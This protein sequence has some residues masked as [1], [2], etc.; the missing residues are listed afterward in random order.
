MERK[1]ETSGFKTATNKATP[2]E[3]DIDKRLC[4]LMCR[5]RGRG[6]RRTGMTVSVGIYSGQGEG[7][8]R[9]PEKTV[10]RIGGGIKEYKSARRLQNAD[11]P[12]AIHD[13][14]C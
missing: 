4:L 2:K 8:G 1:T 3:L 14:V 9:R 11:S 12:L 13:V 5:P 7:A 6:A 10:L